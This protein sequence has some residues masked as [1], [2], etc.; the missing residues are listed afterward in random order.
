MP[1]KSPRK[2]LVQ[3][4]DTSAYETD[5]LPLKPVNWQLEITESDLGKES[6]Q[7]WPPARFSDR[8]DRLALYSRVYT[9]D[10]SDFVKDRKLTRVTVNYYRRVINTVV[11][12]LLRVPVVQ[13]GQP[14]VS[15]Q[16]LRHL[17]A[18][19]LQDQMRYGAALL[20]TTTTDEGLTVGVLDPSTWYPMEGGGDLVTHEYTSP[21]ARSSSHDRVRLY[22]TDG[23]GYLSVQTR[24]LRGKQIGDLVEPVQEVGR[25]WT[26]LVPHTPRVT[27]WGTSIIDDLLP[28]VLEL[29]VQQTRV[30]H[31]LNAHADP[32]LLVSAEEADLDWLSPNGEGEGWDDEW[33]AQPEPDEKRLARATQT[34]R[35][36]RREDVAL[37]PAP[38]FSAE[39]LEWGGKI[40]G[41][42]ASIAL[43]REELG[44]LS[45]IPSILDQSTGAPSGV[46]LK[47]LLILLYGDSGEVQED[48]RVAVESA[49][50]APFE[51]EVV[52]LDWPDALDYFDRETAQPMG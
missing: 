48:T 42:M 27:G 6:R 40:D 44:Y 2:G 7:S 21:E 43:L 52:A 34:I 17:I 51:S 24:E 16:M 28:L 26:E 31:V 20:R 39:F 46:A 10:H 9:G 4:A 41:S 22:L 37:S 1:A 8:N 38:S 14:L 33:P 25:A 47:R 36:L 45:G 11:N 12:L 13:V 3:R 19:C 30:S 35:E 29:A 18:D 23:E 32:T 50:N 49:L 15:E 5:L